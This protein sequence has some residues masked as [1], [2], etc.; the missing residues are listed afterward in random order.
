MEDNLNEVSISVFKAKCL[1]LL[2]QVRLTG[3][4][5]RV[6]RFGKPV[7]DIVPA[8]VKHDRASWIGSMKDSGQILGDIVSPANDPDEWESLR[9]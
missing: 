3:K 7:A 6:T 4:P 2:E 5:L 9:D 1:G 8:T